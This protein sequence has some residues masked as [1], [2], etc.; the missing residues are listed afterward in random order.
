M[1]SP[2]STCSCRTGWAPTSSPR[3]GPGRADPHRA[4]TGR[5]SLEFAE[6][7]D[8]VFYKPFDMLA[9]VKWIGERPGGGNAM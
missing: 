5:S 6:H 4:M 3:S 8:E 7:A 1:T 9:M 2:S